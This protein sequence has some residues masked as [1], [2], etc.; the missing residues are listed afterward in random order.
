MLD[1]EYQRHGVVDAGV[2]V[3]DNGVLQQCLFR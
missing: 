1:G 2:D 3:E